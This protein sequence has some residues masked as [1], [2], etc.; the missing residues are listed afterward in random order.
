MSIVQRALHIK[1]LYIAIMEK[2]TQQELEVL[3]VVVVMKEDYL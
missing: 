1:Q 2:F 3:M